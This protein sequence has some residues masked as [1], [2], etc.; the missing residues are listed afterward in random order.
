MSSVYISV[1][2]FMYFFSSRRRHTICALVT[3]VQT[4]ALP[5]SQLERIEIEVRKIDPVIGA[6]DDGDVVTRGLVVPE[7]AL[8]HRLLTAEVGDRAL[9]ID[10]VIVDRG[11]ESRTEGRLHHHPRRQRISLLRVEIRVPARQRDDIER[12]AGDRVALGA[13]PLAAAR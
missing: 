1:G 10:V 9:D 2:L 11:P 4:C 7:I 12:L 8:V 3:G 13:D 6:G 5:I